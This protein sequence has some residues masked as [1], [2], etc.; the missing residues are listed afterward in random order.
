MKIAI[1]GGGISGLTAAF[2]LDERHEVTLFEKNDYLGGNWA[3]LD[4]KHEEEN[5]AVAPGVAAISNYYYHTLIEL[6]S[7]LKKSDEL[8]PSAPPCWHNRLSIKFP[9]EN[10]EISE[11]SYLTNW[12][13]ALFVW[14]MIKDGQPIL[15]AGD[16]DMS[17]GEFIKLHPQYNIQ[18]F[19]QFLFSVLHILGVKP[20]SRDYMQTPIYFILQ[21]IKEFKVENVYTIDLYEFKSGPRE[22]IKALADHCPHSKILLKSS[23]TDVIEKD[24]L[25]SLTYRHDEETHVEEFD[26][27]IFSCHPPEIL[28]MHPNIP[29]AQALSELK[30]TPVQ[31]VI[32]GDER[33]MP[34]S[35]K[36]WPNFASLFMPYFDVWVDSGWLGINHK[37]K[38]VFCTYA[39]NDLTSNVHIL[40]NVYH[41]MWFEYPHISASSVKIHKE[42]HRQSLYGRIALIGYWTEGIFTSEDGVRSAVRVMP[43]IDK[44]LPHYSKRYQA[45]VNSANHIPSLS[46]GN[47][48]Y[49]WFNARIASPLLFTFFPS[50]PT[51]KS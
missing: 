11:S 2:L 27:V 51:N 17:I 5:I 15:D 20:D 18:L 49:N 25:V 21:V 31:S 12:M 3:T 41:T 44:D 33:V 16:M 38:N 29:C 37:M 14:K 4:I 22:I 26:Y 28:K 6:I 42:M 34:P 30:Y 40:K 46:F 8:I 23:V 9:Y 48:L 1:I 35:K 24:N 7:L 47:K 45:L 36:K 13:M 43:F 39:W 32:H 19:I 50:R 10:L